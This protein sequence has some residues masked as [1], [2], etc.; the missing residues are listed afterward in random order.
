MRCV[1]PLGCTSRWITLNLGSIPSNKLVDN[2][3]K[4]FYV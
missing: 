4:L 2:L 1:T 3:L